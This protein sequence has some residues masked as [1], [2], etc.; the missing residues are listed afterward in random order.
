M[1]LT[2]EITAS[3]AARPGDTTRHVFGEEGGTIGRTRNRSLA[4]TDTKVSGQHAQISFR[5]GVFYIEDTSRNGV[6]VNSPENRL[7]RNRPYALKTGDRLFIEPY[8]V[9]VWIDAASEPAARQPLVDLFVPSA[10]DDPFAA[11]RE[12]PVPS[13]GSLADSGVGGEVDPLKFFHP[14]AG[15]AAAQQPEPSA[16]PI[17]DLLDAH[18]EPPGV[19]PSPMPAKS[20]SAAI[21]QGYDPLAPDIPSVESVAPPPIRSRPGV[22]SPPARGYAEGTPPAELPTIPQPALPTVSPAQPTSQA[23]PP[24]PS[25]PPLD[26][27][28]PREAGKTEELAELLAGAGVPRAAITAELARNLGEILRIVVSGL[29][30]VLQSRQRIK[31]EFRMDP[32]IFRPAEN[33]PLKFSVNVEDALHN[34]LVKR[35]P[36]YLGPVDAFADAFDDLRDHQLAMLAGIRVAFESMLAEFDSDHLQEAFDRQLGRISLPLVPLK[37]RYWDLYREKVRE[38]SKDAEATFGRLFGEEFRQA[39]EEQFRELK[40]QRRSRTPNQSANEHPPRR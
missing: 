27:S 33:N 4:L 21:P 13:V 16:P 8:E 22:D 36:A 38:M 6:A 9:D 32:T 15:R 39:Y 11:R 12:P 35:N 18:Y 17:D 24:A 25:A 28:A 30:D 3:S 31:E 5:N 29:M 2:L 26:G 10:E 20:D 7:V 40:A 37:L 1:T 34:L 14:V 23:A 19:L